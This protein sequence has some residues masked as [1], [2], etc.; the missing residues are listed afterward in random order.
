MEALDVS[1]VLMIKIVSFCL[2]GDT[3]VVV[4]SNVVV[5]FVEIVVVSC[6]GLS[7]SQSNSGH[8][9]SSKRLKY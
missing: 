1:K 9:Q 5:V 3:V 7:K 2:G 6:D 8:G 4:V